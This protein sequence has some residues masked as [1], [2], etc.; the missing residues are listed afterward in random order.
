MEGRFAAAAGWCPL[1]LKRLCGIEWTA[2]PAFGLVNSSTGKDVDT[3]GGQ[4]VAVEEVTRRDY[5]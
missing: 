3:P 4:T 2:T 1:S 5:E